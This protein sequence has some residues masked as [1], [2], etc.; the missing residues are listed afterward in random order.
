MPGSVPARRAGNGRCRGG[1]RAAACPLRIP[2]GPG[3]RQRA[4]EISLRSGEHVDA[5]RVRAGEDPVAARGERRLRQ[6]VPA[7]MRHRQARP[8]TLGQ[9]MRR[10]HVAV[11]HAE[12]LVGERTAFDAVGMENGG[13]RRE[14]R[15]DRRG[16]VFVAPSRRGRSAPSS[17]VRP[18]DRRA[19][20]GAGDDQSVEARVSTIRK[21]R[22]SARRTRAARARRAAHR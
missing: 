16:G 21:G 8:G 18:R 14:A 3:G 22:D 7:R 17:T 5:R 13:M 9:R 12:Q 6:I 1:I 10:Q 15:P 11:E 4:N 2:D 19:R 20:L